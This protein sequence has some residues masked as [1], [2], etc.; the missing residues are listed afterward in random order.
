[1]KMVIYEIS[2]VNVKRCERQRVRNEAK[3][4]HTHLANVFLGYNETACLCL[5][6]HSVN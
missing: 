3:L 6:C 4:M 5:I 1:M 2:L